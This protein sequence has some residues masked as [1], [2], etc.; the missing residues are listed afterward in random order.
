MTIIKKVSTQKAVNILT[1]KGINTFVN[2]HSY[3]LLRKSNDLSYI[4][5][6]YVDGILLVKLFSIFGI[7]VKRRSFDMTSLAPKV[8]RE[9]IEKNKTIYFIGS[10]KNDIIKFVSIIGR[11]RGDLTQ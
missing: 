9:C 5:K 2:P 7:K 4:D 10:K 11:F 3:L 6:I 8:F 1:N